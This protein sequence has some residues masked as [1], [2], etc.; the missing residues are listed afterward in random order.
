MQDKYF[1]FGFGQVAKYF[2]DNLI[3]KKKNFTFNITKTAKSFKKSFKGKKYSSFHF[4]GKKFDK[5]MIKFLKLSNYIIISIPPRKGDPVIKHFKNHLNSTNLKKII[6]LSATSVYGDHDGKWV[7]EKSKLKPT[8]K[9]GKR[10]LK[11]EQEWQKL[12]KND[13]K[14][15]YIL[16]L[17]GIYSKENNPI[18]RL[19]A[20]PKIYINKKNHFFSRI[21]VE[22]IAR[23]I[24]KI[25][26]K[27]NLDGGVF[28]VSDDL[29]ASSETV[30]KYAAKLIKISSLKSVSY[31][32]LKGEMIKNFYKDSKKVR[33][34]KI[35]KVL[36]I[37]LK[38]PSYK[39]GLRD[40]IY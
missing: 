16:R 15:L 22:D 29:P 17:S 2:L 4:D 5:K 34:S 21:R 36:K 19:K 38:Y 25:L 14:K 35:K 9:F 7:N 33:N 30:T 20:G 23:V 18:K 39:K 10:R 26:K 12:F 27:K 11:A 32:N 6:Y 1:F 28:N 13:K 37:N 40:F 8:S 3:K 31:K 24:L